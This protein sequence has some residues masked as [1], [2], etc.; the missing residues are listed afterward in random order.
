MFIKGG[1]LSHIYSGAQLVF[2]GGGVS[3]EVGGRLLKEDSLNI[4]M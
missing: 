3:S 2:E 4:G 1:W